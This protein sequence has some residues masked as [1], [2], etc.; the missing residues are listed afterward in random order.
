[1]TEAGMLTEEDLALRDL[2]RG[3]ASKT[4]AARA[5]ALDRDERFPDEVVGELGALGLSGMLIPEAFGGTEA[6]RL[7]V[8]L[9][10]EEIAR[11]DA[12]TALI[13]MAHLHGTGVIARYGTIE[14]KKRWLPGVAAGEQLAAVALTE[15][16]A[17]TDIK[18]MRSRLVVNGSHYTLNGQKAFISNGDRAD[19]FVVFARMA[20]WPHDGA[21]ISAVV[22]DGRT[23]GVRPGSPVK[24][25]GLRASTTTPVHFD[26]VVVPME[27]RLGA[28]GDGLAI[29]L[30]S[31]DGARMSTAAQAV[32]I[33]QG[34]FERALAYC[35]T[36]EQ[37]GKV[38]AM[39]QAVQIR[40]A[41]MFIGISGARALL[42]EAARMMDRGDEDAS[43]LASA[44][45]VTCTRTAS[46]VASR[47]VEL[48]GGYG[49]VEESD[50]ARY[51]RDAK[52]GEIYDGTN[53]VNRLV[54]ARRLVK[55]AMGAGAPHGG[56][57]A[58]PAVR[59]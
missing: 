39:H 18:S 11:V 23:P 3:Y 5:A 36:R 55:A 20:E 24:K 4:L 34:A 10:L 16:D 21:G 30:Q 1:M 48:L 43:M 59:A 9:V 41:D 6:S 14:A 27:A 52:G 56:V 54:I 50:V 49:F 22:V 51:M 47:A 33:A 44:A 38:I 13:L 35:G 45:K 58:P 28:E 19:V 40:L 26:D 15:P 2:V 53:D 17:G 42:H 37:S 25:L 46:E 12:G 8:S 29:A 7:Q 57:A 31:L 32:G